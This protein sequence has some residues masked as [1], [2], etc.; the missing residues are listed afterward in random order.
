[1]KWRLLFL[2]LVA[3]LAFFACLWIYKAEESDNF[4]R[5][6]ASF[7]RVSLETKNGKVTVSVGTDS[8]ASALITRYAYGKNQSDAEQR[9]SQ[10]TVEDTVDNGCWYLRLNFPRSSAPQG[11]L[12]AASLPERA[13][14]NII[15]SNGQVTVSGMSAGVTV[16]NSN[17]AVVLTGTGGD[18]QVSTSNGD[19]TV[20]V[21]SGGVTIN[22]SNGQIDCDLAAL[23][24][25]KS[26]VL[27][28]TNGKVILRLPPDVSCRITATTSNGTVVISG[29]YVQYEEQ[30]QTRVR[31]KIGSGAASVTVTTTNGD[32]TIQNRLQ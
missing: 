22:T 9:L 12:I 21:H 29:F 32:I 14:L 5:P 19:V 20:Q 1:M 30:S 7:E 2:A 27:N 26:A 10:I 8:A 23:P 17:G 18:A 15:T 25:V 6:V 11:G 31:A 3:G 4:S 24:A 16:S 13:G 28:T